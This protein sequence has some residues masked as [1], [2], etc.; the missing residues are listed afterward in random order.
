[1]LY[2]KGEAH[3]GSSSLLLLSAQ[4]GEK[5]VYVEGPNTTLS[6][7]NSYFYLCASMS[8]ASHT[9]AACKTKQKHSY[10]LHLTGPLDPVG[11]WCRIL[12]GLWSISHWLALPRFLPLHQNNYPSFV[13]A[14]RVGVGFR[15]TALVG[16]NVCE[17]RPRRD[18]RE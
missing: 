11:V 7:V 15:A 17:V 1:M 16:S 12:Q 5:Q 4:L 14:G 3:P 13:G 18:P 9:D 8:S 6:W 2:S 10:K